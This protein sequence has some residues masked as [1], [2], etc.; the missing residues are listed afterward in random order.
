MMKKKE[1]VY[2]QPE[3]NNAL[4]RGERL[5]FNCS[6]LELVIGDDIELSNKAGTLTTEAFITQKAR[7]FYEAEIETDP[8]EHRLDLTHVKKIY[9]E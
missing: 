3:A 5:F 6:E 2:V 7:N 4:K 1:R 8:V 9:F